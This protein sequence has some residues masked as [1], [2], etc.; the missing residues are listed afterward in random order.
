MTLRMS[1]RGR[2][3]LADHEGVVLR[4]YKDVVGVWTI[5]VGHTA[6]AGGIV[7]KP[8]MEITHREAMETLES[9][10]R[11]FEKRVNDQRCFVRQHAFDGATSFDFNTGRIHNAT[12]VKK[13]KRDDAAGAEKSIMAWVKAGG[14]TVKGLVNRRNAERRLI[15]HGDY[16][17]GVAAEGV[18]RDRVV[19]ATHKG[20]DPVVE[21]AQQIL[22]K[23]GFNPGAIDGWWGRNTKKAVLEFQKTHPHLNNDGVLGPATL[24]Q[25][26]RDAKSVKDLMQKGGGSA[27][28]AIAF[29]KSVG[30]PWEWALGVGGVIALIALIYFGIRY[31]DIIAARFN[32]LIGREVA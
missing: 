1:E 16:G 30:F 13:Y 26:R 28:T 18:K 23:R 15:F 3:F 29:I 6:A 10:L 9:D 14:R 32:K 19:P 21:E 11:K 4:A 22:T 12:W 2:K 25:L 20:F 17:H 27:G 7:P 24:A 31:R 8:G 5:G